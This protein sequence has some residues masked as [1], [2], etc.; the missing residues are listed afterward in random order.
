MAHSASPV[1]VPS[2]TLNLV[3]AA[4]AAAKPEKWDDLRIAAK[5][6]MFCRDLEATLLARRSNRD[7]PEQTAYDLRK[8]RARAIRGAI[9][10]TELDKATARHAAAEAFMADA[11]EALLLIDRLQHNAPMR[12]D[13]HG[14][15]W[16][17]SDLVAYWFTGESKSD[18]GK[19]AGY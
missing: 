2:I 6:V 13:G 16:T 9:S 5:P 1:A 15:N 10:R 19:R 14:G 11:A 12:A 4:V 18:A 17:I 7:L 3:S 8:A